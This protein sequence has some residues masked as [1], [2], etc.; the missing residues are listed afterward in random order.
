MSSTTPLT[1]EEIEAIGDADGD[2]EKRLASVHL[3]C[4][5]DLKHIGTLDPF[6]D[7]F[8]L[9]MISIYE[10]IKGSAGYDVSIDEKSIELDDI[11]KVSPWLLK[12]SVYFSS[13][14]HSWAQILEL[15]DVKGDEK[16]LEFGPGSGQI[17]IMLA[18]LGFDVYGVDI[19]EGHLGAVRKQADMLGVKLNLERNIFGKGFD[20][21]MFDRIIFFEAFHHCIDFLQLLPIMRS[22]LTDSG[23]IIFC[24]EPITD[25]LCDSVPYPWGP[26]LD[27][28]SVYCIRKYGWMELGFTREF[29]IDALQRSGFQV[30]T[31][32]S[33]NG[34]AVAHVARP[35]AP[36]G[37]DYSLLLMRLNGKLARASGKSIQKLL[38]GFV[39]KLLSELSLTVGKLLS[40]FGDWMWKLQS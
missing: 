22:R 24:G 31:F 33:V 23:F 40:R 10:S 7:E 39:I 13:F 20:G 18:R 3:A 17:L 1:L 35:S 28:L 8:R 26:R 30:Q 9:E 2:I 36:G 34:R 27:G 32:P 5:R 25:A 16:I 4:P 38:P 6:S 37:K 11:L 29:F 14:L 12:D 19:D 15:L 21:Q